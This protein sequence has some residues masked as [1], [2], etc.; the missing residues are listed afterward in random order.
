MRVL[1]ALAAIALAAPTA[2]AAADVTSQVVSFR[3]LYFPGEVVL[4]HG[5]RL[6]LT[7]LDPEVHNVVSIDTG[8]DGRPLF[9]SY[10]AGQGQTAEVQRVSALEPGG[11]PFYCTVHEDM[12]GLLTVV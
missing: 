10:L 7:N 1:A 5:Q 11:H 12:L 3:N 8:T 6:S 2:P 4:V 9:E